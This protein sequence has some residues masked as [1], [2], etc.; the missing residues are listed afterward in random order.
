MEI[1]VEG[2]VRGQNNGGVEYVSK[3]GA[4]CGLL[5]LCIGSGLFDSMCVNA[6]LYCVLISEHG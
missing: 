6:P 1:P 4:T 3:G 2:C 5:A